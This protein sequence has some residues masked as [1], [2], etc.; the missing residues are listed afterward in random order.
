MKKTGFSLTELLIIIAIVV[1]LAV[2]VVLVANPT[3]MLAKSRDAQRHDDLT[4]L[5]TAVDLYLADN[6]DFT[7]LSGPYRS[8]GQTETM[9]QKNDGS[10]WIPLKFNL[11]SSGA[12]FGVLALDP[13]NNE[14]Y[15]Y[16]FAV[17]PQNKTYEIDCI[18]ELQSNIDKESNDGG[19]NINAYEVG[20][21]LT[22]LP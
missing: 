22:L 16:T 21:D 19:N 17:N 15:H 8:I 18:F 10:G 4:A 11:I 7:G 2:V 20:T 6:R 5:S 12:P 1:V 9:S 3:K 13:I 14:N